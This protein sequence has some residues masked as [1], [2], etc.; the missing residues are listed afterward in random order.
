MMHWTD[1]V[2]GD[3]LSHG[4]GAPVATPSVDW[5]RYLDTDTGDI[6]VYPPGGPWVQEQSGGGGVS[7]HGDLDG[8]AD[9]DHPHYVAKAIL[10]AKGDLVAAS[11]ADTP[12][13]L[14]VGAN[15]TVL[16]A[17]SGQSTGLKWVPS[18]TPSTQ[19][20]G[21]AAAEGTADT[22]ARGDHKHAM[23]AVGTAHQYLGYNTVGGSQENVTNLRVYLKQ[24]IVPAGG[25]L[26]A[27]IGAHLINATDHAFGMTTGVWSDSGG[28]PDLLLF[29]AGSGIANATGGTG[30]LHLYLAT[31]A[32]PTYAA[33]WVHMP[34]GLYVPAGTY[35]VG[36]QFHKPA[37]TLNL[38]YDDSGSDV[39]WTAGG[40]YLSHGPR[41]SNT[42]SSN[43]YS[44]RASLI[45]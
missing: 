10:D 12:A 36:C 11:A 15:D 14:T 31:A 21:D 16:M 19:A 26:I 44:I 28:T 24:I 3:A 43:R 45:Q 39:Y 7:D 4:S 42:V 18:Q 9:D 33:S 40:M 17:D 25:G 2:Q 23:P 30:I 20:F 37:G 6:Y 8:L 5:A 35:W 13:K 27:S 22:Y 38:Y 34:C 32:T 1:Q 41:F 29:S